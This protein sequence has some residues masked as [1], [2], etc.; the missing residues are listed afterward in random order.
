[1]CVCVCEGERDVIEV[2]DKVEDGVMEE[3]KKRE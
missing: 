2:A 3:R 1:M